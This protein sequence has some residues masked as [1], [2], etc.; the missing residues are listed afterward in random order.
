MKRR[1]CLLIIVFALTVLTAEA[2]IDNPFF[3][4]V[5]GEWS[6]KGTLFGTPA[7]FKMSWQKVL[8]RQFIHLQFSNS[9]KDQNGNTQGIES[10]AYYRW[11]GSSENTGY[12]FDSRGVMFGLKFSIEEDELTVLWGDPKIEEGR[13]EY[14]LIEG[15]RIE[16]KDFVKRNGVFTQFGEAVYTKI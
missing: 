2:Q 3:D 16:V 12:W 1:N 6:G 14:R 13:T 15:N 8:S 5:E 10:K 7:T 11:S 4:K 9:F